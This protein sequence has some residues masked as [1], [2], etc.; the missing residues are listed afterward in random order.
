MFGIA[1]ISQMVGAVLGFPPCIIESKMP[2][3]QLSSGYVKIA[4]WKMAI[5]I[6][7]VN[8]LDM[9]MSHSYASH[10]QRVSSNQFNKLA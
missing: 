1:T 6:V 5:E 3:C 2:I 10:Y 7:D 8:P 4:N 9:V